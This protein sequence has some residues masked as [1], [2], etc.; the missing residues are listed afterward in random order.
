MN[1]FNKASNALLFAIKNENIFNIKS[2]LIPKF[3]CSDFV[4]KLIS[5]KINILFYETDNLYTNFESIEKIFRGKKN[6]PDAILM[7]NYFGQKILHDKFLKISRKYNVILIEDDCH[8]FNINL[9][10][11]KNMNTLGDIYF[12]SQRKLLNLKYGASYFIKKSQKDILST[13]LLKEKSSYLDYII[14]KIINKIPFSRYLIYKVSILKNKNTLIKTPQIKLA[15]D[16]SQKKIILSNWKILSVTRRK[17]WNLWEKELNKI[18]YN[19]PI[20]LQLDSCPW[21]I[22]VESKNHSNYNKLIRFLSFYNYVFFL[23]PDISYFNNKQLLCI[24]LDQK[25]LKNIY[26]K[27]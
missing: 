5:N 7:V 9:I 23:W 25:P 24:R 16:F 12:T 19:V 8:G 10:S 4:Y 15:D 22:P 14:K 27:F 2:I 18:G 21:S 13:S 3:I 17:N 1:I 11:K 26:A 20:N 6:K